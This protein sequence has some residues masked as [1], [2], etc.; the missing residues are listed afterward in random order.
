MVA[1][2]SIPHNI[3]KILRR[4]FPQHGYPIAAVT[5]LARQ[6]CNSRAGT[7][8]PLPV[9]LCVCALLGGCAAM[10]ANPGKPPPSFLVSG[11]KRP[12]FVIGVLI[13]GWHSGIVLPA[14]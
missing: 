10:P 9:W 4:G 8:G 2:S 14:D 13:A 6:H 1:L 11:A 3:I 5:E 12:P 7:P